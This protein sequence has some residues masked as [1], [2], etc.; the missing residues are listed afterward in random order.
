MNT[1]RFRDFIIYKNARKFR[2]LVREELKKFPKSESYFLRDQLLRSSL[3]I[4]LNIAEGSAKGS[5]KDFA[6][7]L[8][9]SIASLNEVVA[10]FDAAF[11]DR[12][13]SSEQLAKIEH[14]GETLAKS[15]GSFIQVLR[16]P[17]AKSQ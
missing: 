11:D 14:A 9:I 2:W 15:I 17:N 10:G 1:F 16:K 13:I 7:Y 12:A 3:S 5:D 8:S 4:I 6:R